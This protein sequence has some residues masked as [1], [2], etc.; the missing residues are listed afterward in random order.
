MTLGMEKH[1]RNSKKQTLKP[2]AIQKTELE[3]KYLILKE[4]LKIVMEHR[5]LLLN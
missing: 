4:T 2:R 3:Q 5:L 1:L